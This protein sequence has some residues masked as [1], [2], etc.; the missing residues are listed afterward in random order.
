MARLIGRHDVGAGPVLLSLLDQ[1]G[2]RLIDERLDLPPLA[3]RQ[4]ADL[5]DILEALGLFTARFALLYVL[6]YEDLLRT[7]G[8][9]PSGESGEAVQEMVK[10]L[11]SQPVTDDIRGP[12]ITNRPGRRRLQSTVMGMTVEVVL[13]G[14]TTMTLVAEAVLASVEACFATAFEL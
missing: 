13:D 1:V 3:L 10:R 14:T 7:D 11:A 6:G 2:E 4:V 9:L 5:P 8:S 12:L